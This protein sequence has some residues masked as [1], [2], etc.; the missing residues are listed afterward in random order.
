MTRRSR[1][2]P[3]QKPGGQ[4]RLHRARILACLDRDAD[5]PNPADSPMGRVFMNRQTGEFIEVAQGASEPSSSWLAI[6]IPSHGQRHKWFRV[7]L[8]TI[9][10]EDE[11]FGSIGRWL[12]EHASGVRAELWSNFRSERVVA[13]AIA[14]CR[15]A[16]IDAEA[17]TAS[18]ASDGL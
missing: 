1:Q 14:A 6:P 12:K 3:V 17:V 13:Y 5:Y 10:R 11:Y 7:F 9:G 2:F 8:G 16:G 4:L 15:H 18:R